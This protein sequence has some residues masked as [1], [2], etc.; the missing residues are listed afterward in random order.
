[1]VEGQ[2]VKPSTEVLLI[3]PFKS[4]W[5][6]DESSRKSRAILEFTYIEF[7][8]SALKTNPYKGYETE[9]RRKVLKRDLMESSWQEDELIKAGMAKIEEFQREGSANYTLYQDAVRA[10]ER[11]QDFLRDFDI[12][13]RTNS[14]SLILKPKDITGSLLDIDKVATSLNSLEKKV[15]E[16]LYETTRMRSNKDISI[17]AK[18]ENLR[19]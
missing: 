19:R 18:P 16:D 1:M 15:E 11:L 6:R 14:G 2:R 3:E 10:K 13:S 7:M 4:I 8:T 9:K 12:N 5:E 17:F